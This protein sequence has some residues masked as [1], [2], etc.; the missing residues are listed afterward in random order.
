MLLLKYNGLCKSM[1]S[2][3]RLERRP[4]N[5]VAQNRNLNNLNI[6]RILEVFMDIRIYTHYRE[7]EVLALY[8]S[9]GWTN[10]TDHPEMLRRASPDRTWFWVLTKASC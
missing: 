2:T 3:F 9:V 4:N 8:K 10:Y 1:L 5:E 7:G 6:N